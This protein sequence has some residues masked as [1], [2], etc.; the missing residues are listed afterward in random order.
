LDN[1]NVN[2]QPTV[3][4][5]DNNP[6]IE[7]FRDY[8]L[9]H[10]SN[11]E[12]REVLFSIEQ[13]TDQNVRDYLQLKNRVLTKSEWAQFVAELTG[14]RESVVGTHNCA[15]IKKY[16]LNLCKENPAIRSGNVDEIIYNV[17]RLQSL[18]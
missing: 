8:L 7:N 13:Y 11:R 4:E 3:T 5:G 16:V 18:Q 2:I 17:I 14:E 10:S 15:A 9:F 12:T 6:Q 1:Q